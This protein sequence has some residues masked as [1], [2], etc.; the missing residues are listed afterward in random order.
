MRRVRFLLIG[1]LLGVV[2]LIGAAMLG[3]GDSA[4]A[5]P[6]SVFRL[7]LTNLSDP[8]TPLSPGALVSH[9]EEGAF[10]SRGAM[11]SPELELIAEVGDPGAAV[12]VER[13]DSMNGVNFIQERH[14]IGEVGPGQ[15]T[16]VELELNFGCVLSTAHM[17][18][19]SN[20][21]FVGVNSLDVHDE[22]NGQDSTMVEVELRAYD[23]GTEENTE[24]G[25]GFAGGQPD[26]TRG[27]ANLDNGVPTAEP[28]S[29][30]VEW[31]G[32]QATL[33]IELVETLEESGDTDSGQ[34]MQDESDN[35]DTIGFPNG[36]TG[37]LATESSQGAS[38]LTYLLGILAAVGVAGASFGLRRRISRSR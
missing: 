29:S 27:A 12:A 19:E 33:T 20:D 6:S 23:A 1:G 28:I 25:S 36:G 14:T 8:P 13:Q 9:C 10:W 3:A 32:T 35:E 16:T 22:L 31:P 37:G 38:T 15:S 4:S 24:P 7:T 18:V 2:A 30:S 11:A 5:T 21:S 34:M 17:L 26:P